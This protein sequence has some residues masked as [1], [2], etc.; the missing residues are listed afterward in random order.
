MGHKCVYVDETVND[1]TATLRT[2]FFSKESP[3]ELERVSKIEY[4]ILPSQADC[5]VY[6]TYFINSLKPI[7][8][9]SLRARDKISENITLPELHFIEYQNPLL[10]KWKNLLKTEQLT[11]FE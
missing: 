11:L 5:L 10:E 2:H 3:I 6:K 8:N 9:N 7:Y 4:A 1:L